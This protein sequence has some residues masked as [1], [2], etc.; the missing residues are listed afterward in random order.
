[1]KSAFEAVRA[2]RAAICVARLQYLNLLLV[3]E[4]AVSMLNFDGLSRVGIGGG[5]DFAIDF[6]ASWALLVVHT[7]LRLG[8]DVCWRELYVNGEP[9]FATQILG[10]PEGQQRAKTMHDNM[11]HMQR[12]QA[13]TQTCLADSCFRSE[14]NLCLPFAQ[15]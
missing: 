15:M 3:R 14:L 7:N 2:G 1:M 9:E 12:Q 10:D 5:L 4:I 13:Y 11:G 6:R 8:F